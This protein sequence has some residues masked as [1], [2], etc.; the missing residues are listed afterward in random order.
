MNSET[1]TLP[2]VAFRDVSKR[3][4]MISDQPQTILEALL[5]IFREKGLRASN[6]E[7]W[8]VRDVSFDLMPG[9]SLGLVGRNGSGKSTVLKLLTRILRPTSGRIT[10]R[11]RVS[12]LLELGAGFH[13][14]LTGR[15]NIY[16]NASVLGLTKEQVETSFQSIVAFSE[17]EEFIDVPVKH[18][19]SGM[20]MRLGFSV[21]IHVH[22]D[23]LIIDEI[24][25]VGD[26]AFQ[27][28]CVD[29]IYQLKRRGTTIVM[30]SHNLNIIRNLCGRLIWL[31]QGEV[32]AQGPT[33][34][35]APQY[36]ASTYQ[37]PA[38]TSSP[39]RDG[40]DFKRWGTRDVEITGVRFLTADGRER[41]TFH[42]GEPLTVQIAYTAH[43]AVQDAEF[44]LAIFRQDG[45]QINSPNNRRAGEQ[46]D[47]DA[48]T[49]IVRYCVE[50][51]PLLPGRYYLTVAVHDGRT[52]TAYDF[53][54]QAYS[55]HVLPGGRHD[56]DGIMQLP[57]TWEWHPAT[58]RNRDRRE[59]GRDDI[60]DAPAGTLS[61]TR[62]PAGIA[63]PSQSNELRG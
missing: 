38:H 29:Q 23:I 32:R 42:T 62:D 55:F 34:L 35:I 60:A 41:A 47:L 56:L 16:L 61:E 39:D 54:E 26:Q 24:L 2:A 4:R 9:D 45:L 51:L 18:Y 57:A 31:E 13:Q 17:L 37:N 8:A 10:I 52:A 59:S 3:F 33:E 21:A 40:G 43:R 1:Q 49:G 5:A 36:L 19:S 7:L 44:G 48:G 25:A 14:D 28:K 63:H 12:A 6:R 22:P 58:E 11:G 27:E 30:V 15:E 46:I 50:R 20:Y 53:H